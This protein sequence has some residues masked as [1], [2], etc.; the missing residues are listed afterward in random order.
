M[1][2]TLVKTVKSQIKKFAHP[3]IRCLKPAPHLPTKPVSTRWGSDRG[4]PIDIYFIDGFLTRFCHHIQGRVLEIKNKRYTKSLGQGVTQGDVLDIDPSNPDA[5]V[6]ADLAAADSIPDN[7]YDCFILTETLQYI[8]DF[9]SAV[10]HCHRIL[11]PGGVL[12]VTVPCI[13]PIDRE[14]E[15]TEYWRFTKNSCERLFGEAFKEGQVEIEAH[16]NYFSCSAFL[17]GMALEEVDKKLLQDRWPTFVQGV[18]VRAIKA[19]S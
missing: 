1:S 12:L 3:A 16:G 10:A 7:T 18:C 6:I 9:K 15:D 13:S 4:T 14:L 2:D 8:Y 5:N 17:A 19:K 11:K